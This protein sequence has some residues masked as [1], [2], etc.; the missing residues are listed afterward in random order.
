MG[1]I[2]HLLHD[3]KLE[4]ILSSFVNVAAD[5]DDKSLAELE[6]LIARKKRDMG[7]SE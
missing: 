2:I 3:G 1:D 4:T 5:L 6:A 7:A